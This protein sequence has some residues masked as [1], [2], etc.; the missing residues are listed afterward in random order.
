M[1]DVRVDID[2]L[3]GAWRRA[4]QAAQA[5]LHSAGADH[6]MTG[7]ELQLRSRRLS[8]E[9]ADLVGVLGAFAHDGYA[10]PRLV[11]LLGSPVESRKLLDLPPGVESCIFNGDGILVASTALQL[12]AWR[13]LF[14]QF[15]ARQIERTGVTHAA[16]SRRSDYPELVYGRS[17][18]DA[19]RAFL[20]SRGITL[21]EGDADDPPESDTVHGLAN[22]KNMLL[23]RR[24]EEHGLRAFD[25]AR[26]YLQLV[27][28]A[29]LHSA[30]ISGSTNARALLERADLLGLI[31]EVVDGN[32]ARAEGLQ[33]KPAPDIPLA[34]C[35]RLGL[36]PERTALFETSQDGVRAGIA[37]GFGYVVVV[38]QEAHAPPLHAAGADRV[39]ADLG[40]ILEHG[41]G[42]SATAGRQRR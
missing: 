27:R 29:G 1:P 35:R 33:R 30:V 15:I 7:A 22:R 6:D 37:G 21:P 36:G 13:E 20:L 10:R 8:D 3:I 42:G 23:F 19:V 39:V 2:V 34:A 40:E 5:A 41:L 24:L 17:R 11:R 28:D 12:D 16:F 26:L 4:L 9:R 25:G 32:A 18:E 14:N 38:D 31:D